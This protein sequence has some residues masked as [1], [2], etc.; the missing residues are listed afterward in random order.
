MMA[1]TTKTFATFGLGALSLVLGCSAGPSGS[2][3]RHHSAARHIEYDALTRTGFERT[4]STHNEAAEFFVPVRRGRVSSTFGYRRN[5]FNGAVQFH[6]GVDIAVD[7]GTPVRACWG[8]RVESVEWSRGSGHQVRLSHPGGR[9]TVYKHLSAVRVARGRWVD[10]GDQVG[11]S[12]N[13]GTM[14]TGPHLHLETIG[15]GKP[16]DPGRFDSRLARKGSLL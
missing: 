4:E 12:G 16:L 1:G 9:T 2:L 14:S 6:R 8:G 5:P 3:R 7:T 15:G 10:G 11:A 13:T